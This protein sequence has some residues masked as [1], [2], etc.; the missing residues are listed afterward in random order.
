[1]VLNVGG[2]MLIMCVSVLSPDLINSYK[3]LQSQFCQVEYTL[4]IRE[5]TFLRWG[6]RFNRSLVGSLLLKPF[7]SDP[8]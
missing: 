8:V 5:E 1:M 4:H 2:G 7:E 3:N 6:R